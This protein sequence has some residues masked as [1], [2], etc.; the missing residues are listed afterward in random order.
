MWLIVGILKPPKKP[1]PN[2]YLALVSSETCLNL[3]LPSQKRVPFKLPGIRIKYV[4][5]YGFLRP[6]TD[7]SGLYTGPN[8]TPL[9]H[10]QNTYKIPTKYVFSVP[11]RILYVF[12]TGAPQSAYHWLEKSKSIY[13]SSLI[14]IYS[15]LSS[16]DLC[17][18]IDYKP[19]R[20][21]LY[22]GPA[23]DA[24]NRTQKLPPE[25]PRPSNSH[26]NFTT[27]LFQLSTVPLF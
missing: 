26:K 5:P 14:C 20:V 12:R 4:I 13:D 11:V 2:A 1:S 27:P 25:K 23:Q 19:L 15:D 8:F 6:F 10:V 18:K 9:L 16:R 17:Y 3:I 21:D 7:I 24:F 22:G